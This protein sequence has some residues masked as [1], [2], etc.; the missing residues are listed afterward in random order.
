MLKVTQTA[1][2]DLVAVH[3]L[4]YNVEWQLQD[5]D[6]CIISGSPAGKH[7]CEGPGMAGPLFRA[8]PLAVVPR[9]QTRTPL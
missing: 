6:H 8:A 3:L 7:V 2:R 9:L 1:A 5:V 4:L